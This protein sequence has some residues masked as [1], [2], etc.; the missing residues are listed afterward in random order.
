M[1]TPR[2]RNQI[3]LLALISGGLAVAGTDTYRKWVVIDPP[4][5]YATGTETYYLSHIRY[6]NLGERGG[7]ARKLL[8]LP[9]RTDYNRTAALWRRE[10]SGAIRRMLTVAL[11]DMKPERHRAD[12]EAMLRED[13]R[14]LSAEDQWVK[15]DDVFEG[16]PVDFAFSG[17]REAAHHLLRQG[18]HSQEA[19]T[20][21]LKGD[22][23]SYSPAERRA[24]KATLALFPGAPAYHP[25]VQPRDINDSPPKLTG[26]VEALRSWYGANASRL[27]WNPTQK[28]YSMS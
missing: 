9:G 22:G 21:L 3:A 4:A 27:H 10:S 13:T 20:V 17:A 15:T 16:E 28:R 23:L 25:E 6:G 8:A 11:F 12:L 2:R 18:Y 7:A 5:A 24:V 26:E 19:F 1:I 14:S